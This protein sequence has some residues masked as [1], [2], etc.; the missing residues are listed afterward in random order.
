MI[1]SNIKDAEVSPG[2]CLAKITTVFV[3]DELS[4]IDEFNAEVEPWDFVRFI[5]LSF[6]LDL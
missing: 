5:V 6:E 1:P 3:V 2:C 4:A